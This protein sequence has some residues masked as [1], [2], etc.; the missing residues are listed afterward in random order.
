MLATVAN[1]CSNVAE[2]NIVVLQTVSA[3]EVQLQ[4]EKVLLYPNP[5]ADKLYLEL[6]EPVAGNP[7]IAIYDLLGRSI[8]L[9]GKAANQQDGVLQLDIS[10]LP[11]SVYIVHLNLDDRRFWTGKFVKK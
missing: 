4:P 8:M 6:L 9:P 2:K 11:P 7:Q 5:S 10:T 3:G 1:G